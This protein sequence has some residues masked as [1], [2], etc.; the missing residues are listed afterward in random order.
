[1]K[2]QIKDDIANCLKKD[3]LAEFNKDPTQLFNQF[4]NVRKQLLEK[5]QSNN[6]EEPEFQQEDPSE[7]E[8]KNTGTDND[9]ELLRQTIEG[10]S[11]EVKKQQ[12]IIM[13]NAFAGLD[14]LICED[15]VNHLI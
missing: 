3:G 11:S 12:S 5:H 7:E 15:L 6:S 13:A 1:M 14:V 4:E 2:S 10:A 8:R 9:E